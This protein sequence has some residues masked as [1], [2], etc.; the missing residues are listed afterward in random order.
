MKKKKSARQIPY[1]NILDIFL[2]LSYANKMIT[3]LN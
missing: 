1:H 2:E 3:Y